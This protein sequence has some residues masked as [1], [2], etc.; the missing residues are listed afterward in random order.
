VWPL[1]GLPVALAGCGGA[2]WSAAA[3]ATPVPEA[4]LVISGS[5][6]A[7]PLVQELARGFT[8]QNPAATFRF[9]SGT[10]TG[11]AIRGLV[12][13]TMDL[14]AANRTLTEAELRE[15][16]MA[17][18]FAH[19]AVA[20]AVNEPNAL[21]GLT[22]DRLQQVYA[23]AVT[24]WEQ[25]GGLPGAIVVLDRD[26]DESAR[27]D[28]LLPFMA[29][30]PVAARTVVLPLA[31]EMVRALETTPRSVGYSTV[32]LLSVLQARN[33]RSLTLDGIV[34]GRDALVAGR[35][36]WSLTYSLVSRGDAPAP[37]R[38]FLAF[39]TSPAGQRILMALGVAAL[40]G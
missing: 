27:K 38:R 9:E 15:G 5:G 6:T 22:T 19:D 12:Q 23:G 30:R 7:L 25:L 18:P 37:V 13:G 39:A 34:P 20:F 26:A 1:I 4:P 10:N 40:G 8:A 2:P 32:G 29:G 3:V 24:D 16:L 36:P 14:A 33:V 21:Q 31:P 35:H 28:I 17:Q 11:G